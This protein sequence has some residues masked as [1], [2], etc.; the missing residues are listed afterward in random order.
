[1]KPLNGNGWT[2]LVKAMEVCPIN[3]S[4][5]ANI[6]WSRKCFFKQYFL[7]HVNGSSIQTIAKDLQFLLWTPGYMYNVH[8]FIKP[9]RKSVMFG[10]YKKKEQLIYRHTC[11]LGLVCWPIGISRGSNSWLHI[12]IGKEKASLGVPVNIIYHIKLLWAKCVRPAEQL[13]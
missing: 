7:K 10:S 8:W 9:W 4:S 6:N 12:P 11:R 5:F 1:M 13:R 2:Y 3:F